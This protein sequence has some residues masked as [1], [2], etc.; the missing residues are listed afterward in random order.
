[1]LAFAAACRAAAGAGEPASGSPVD[2]IPCERAEGS[3]LHV[4]QHL[5]LYDRGKPELIPSDVGRPILGDCVY[6]IHTHTPDGIIHVES[7]VVRTFTLGQFFDLWGEPLG[8]RAAGPARVLPGRIV[9]YLNGRRYAGDPRSIPL[10]A[11]ADIVIE[12]GPPYFHP[13]PFTAWGEL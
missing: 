12:A 6:W 2:G 8:P 5:A 1:M 9:V 10:T 7:P 11:H 4:H 3:A 13:A